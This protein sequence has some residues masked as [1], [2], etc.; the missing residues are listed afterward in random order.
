[1]GVTTRQRL[2]CALAKLDRGGAARRLGHH[3][4]GYVEADCGS[5]T[6]CGGGGDEAWAG[7]DIEDAVA[8]RH[9]G[10]VKK[11]WG[12]LGGR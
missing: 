9:A 10:S 4:I 3:R 11:R 7:S 12:D 8:T 6:F 5:S 2:G 1:M